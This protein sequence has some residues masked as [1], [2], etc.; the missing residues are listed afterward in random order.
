MSLPIGLENMKTI[1]H[2]CMEDL[3]SA[4]LER[5]QVECPIAHHF[6][7]GIYV[8]EMF[9]PAGSLILGHEHKHHHG[10]LLLKGTIRQ[11]T[12]DGEPVKELS[13]PLIFTAPPGRKLGFA[14][15]DVIFCNLFATEETDPAKIEEQVVIKSGTWSKKKIK[16]AIGNLIPSEEREQL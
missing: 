7:P 16:E 6:M 1:S 15:T 14:V 11:F 2:E 10:C 3:E 4:M 12:V 8:R 9:V 5:P 13:A